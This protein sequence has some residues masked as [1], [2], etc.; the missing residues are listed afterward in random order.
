MRC[1]KCDMQYLAMDTETNSK[2]RAF[3][4]SYACEHSS[5]LYDL[6][7]ESERL[8]AKKLCED[9]NI[10]KV[11]HS[12]TFDI[13]SLS[14]RDINVVKPY[15]CT[16]ILASLL[17][18]NFS[19]K[20]LKD[21]A[22]LYL[23]EDCAEETALKKVLVGLRKE[24]KKNGTM[25]S[26]EDVPKDILSPYCIQDSNYTIKLF[27]L[28]KENLESLPEYASIMK[29]YAFECELIE[30]VVS[31]QK[32]G[33]RLNRPYIKEII[34][35]AASKVDKLQKHIVKKTDGT[36]IKPTSGKQVG[37]YLERF[38][39]PNLECT[40]KGAIKTSAD[41]LRELQIKI[42]IICSV[43]EYRTYNKQLSTYYK[44]FITH[45]TTPK[46]WRAHFLFWQ[47]GTKTG[48]FSAQ[49][50][51]TM[52]RSDDSNLGFD[53]RKA[54]IPRKNYTIVCIDYEAIEMRLFVHWAKA[55]RMAKHILN[56]FDCHTGTSFDL[57]GR[58]FILA[59]PANEQ[60]KYR[61]VA[62]TI[63]FAIIYGAG[64]NRI[65][66]TIKECGIEF[67]VRECGEILQTYYSKYPVQAFMSKT[68][69]DLYKQGHIRLQVK[70]ELLDI[71]RIYHVTQDR[72]YKAANVIIQGC[73]AYVMKAGMLRVAKLI[74]KHNLPCNLMATVHDE[75]IFEVET[76]SVNKVV[77]MLVAQME[78]R[79]SFDVP[80]T[81]A[82]KKSEK[83]WGE[84]K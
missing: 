68:I 28:F 55:E 19:S 60:K 42:P 30:I 11:F 22:R 76:S 17:N 74:K 34:K 69:S 31:M 10:S 70:S 3:L 29:M 46:N 61:R 24:A 41:I 15:H 7:I 64:N 80:I 51:Q 21:M 5:G 58:K 72:S 75:L 14:Q 84:C 71:D 40:A 37:A 77:P 13:Y 54:F 52:P 1:K 59:L 43:L 45:Y 16:F 57:F 35:E 63:N 27:N 50:I 79:I 23:N 65:Y 82:V 25:L 44:P 9:P 6:R 18:E 62:K 83:S 33:M 78:D 81:A 53:V 48:R 32:M 8:K 56:G 49:L 73:A 2:A 66:Q 38:D 12:A 39:L 36:I 67:S 26:Y 47:S 4:M 20:H